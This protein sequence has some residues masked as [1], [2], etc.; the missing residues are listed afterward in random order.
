MRVDQ[1]RKLIG[2]SGWKLRLSTEDGVDDLGR[3]ETLLVLE[4]G[5]ADLDARGSAVEGDGIVC[6]GLSG[7]S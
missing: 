4:G 3:P 5:S 2:G 1:N 6:G 7:R